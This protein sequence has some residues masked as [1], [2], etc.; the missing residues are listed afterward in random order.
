MTFEIFISYS[1][2]DKKFRDKLANHLSN[3]RRLGVISDW[4]DGDIIPGSEWKPQI[5]RHL[6]TA[7]VILLLISADFMASDFCYSIEMQ[8]AIER[9]HR[10]EA[11][12]IPILLRSI[13]YKGSPFERLQILPSGAVPVNKWPLADDAYKDIVEGIRRVIDSMTGGVGTGP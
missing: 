5:L 13:D 6:R 2:K 1:H 4:Y 3:L 10:N 8:E 7:Q 9:H 12:V 11:R